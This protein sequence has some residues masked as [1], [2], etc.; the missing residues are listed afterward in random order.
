MEAVARHR[1]KFLAFAIPWQALA[2]SAASKGQGEA[3]RL[4]LKYGADIG[5][6][7][8]KWALNQAAKDATML[9]T[10]YEADWQGIRSSSRSFNMLAR[11]ALFHGAVE[12]HWFLDHGAKMDRSDIPGWNGGAVSA[13]AVAA[14]LNRN[15]GDTGLYRVDS[16]S[17]IE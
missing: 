15:G 9:D 11:S 8:T 3:F 14:L 1:K 2:T 17:C 13:P 4:C 6:S 16:D 5:N 7:Y 10:L 12:V